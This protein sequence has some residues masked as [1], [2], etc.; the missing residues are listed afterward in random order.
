MNQPLADS[1]FSASDFTVIPWA[2]ADDHW[3][4]AVGRAVTSTQDL[5][6]LIFPHHGE[7]LQRLVARANRENIPLLIGG[8]GTK[9]SW[10]GLVRSPR[11][12]VSLAR[13]DRIIDHAVK[14]LTITVEAGVTLGTL[15]SHLATHQQFL[16]ING[17]HGDRATLGGIVATA[18][19]GSWRQGYGSV[20]DFILGISFVRHDGQMAKAG[21]RVV[22]NVA[23]YDLMK[24]LTQ[25]HG[26][27]GIIHSLTLRA[28]PQTETQETMV[29]TGD[30]GAIAQLAQQLHRSTLTPTAAE[31]FNGAIAQDFFR[32]GQGGILVEFSS[33]GE[34]VQ[35]QGDRLADWARQGGLRCDRLGSQE[36]ATL[37][38]QF[39]ER[40]RH[41]QRDGEITGKIGILPQTI[42]PFLET[43]DQQTQGWATVNLNTGIGHIRLPEDRAFHLRQLQRLRQFCQTHQGYLMVWDSPPQL[44]KELDP[45]GYGGNALGLMTRIKGQ[46]DP[47]N[48]FNPQRFVGGL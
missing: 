48:I 43:F 36:A 29:I 25:S 46:F 20:R 2:A 44:K 13:L 33:I 26:S 6:W 23:G 32:Q 27:L 31:I 11:W 22:K 38:A 42:V 17:A 3:Q 47:Q 21:G 35:A 16:P 9:L 19:T 24:L 45:W 8:Q 34:S 10:G 4:R 40:V 14:D 37:W 30:Y 1:F 18:D 7:A 12:V 5:E 39:T 28:Y 41:G 15:Q